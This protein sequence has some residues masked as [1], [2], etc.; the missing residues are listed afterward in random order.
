MEFGKNM[1]KILTDWSIKPKICSNPKAV[2][3]GKHCKLFWTTWSP[4]KQERASDVT[5][6]QPF[7][8]DLCDLYDLAQPIP[9]FQF[10][11]LN[12]SSINAIS[13]WWYSKSI[14]ISI[15]LNEFR[16]INKLKNIKTFLPQYW[17]KILTKKWRFLSLT[18]LSNKLSCQSKRAIHF[19][20]SSHRFFPLI[21][22]IW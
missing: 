1:S 22:S 10:Y 17:S 9:K 16:S 3:I 5:I 14:E 15:I 7:W 19:S 8:L 6:W 13:V 4:R 20:M 12:I 11:F 2:T 21:S 18:T